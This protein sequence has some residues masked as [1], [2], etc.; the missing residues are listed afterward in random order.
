MSRAV[1]RARGAAPTWRCVG[2]GTVMP[3]VE[4]T[5]VRA[6]RCTSYPQLDGV[7]SVKLGAPDELR[8]GVALIRRGGRDAASDA[9]RKT[10][11][12][13][14]IAVD[15]LASVFASA[16]AP[17]RGFI[18]DWSAATPD[19]AAHYFVVRWACP[20]FLAAMAMA[21]MLA[22]RRVLDLGAGVGHLAGFLRAVAPPTELMIADGH[23]LH[24]LV[25]RT[26]FVPGVPA[27]CLDL[28]QPLPLPDAAFDAVVLSD[29]FHYV[30]RKDELLREVFRV[31]APEG[32]LVL[33]HV[34]D[35]RD[36]TG[37]RVPGAP[38]TPAACGSM[39]REA[40]LGRVRVRGIPEDALVDTL[41]DVGGGVG[42]RATHRL[43]EMPAGPYAMWGRRSHEAPAV[44]PRVPWERAL[45]A[46]ELIA[47]PIYAVRRSRG[48]WRLT[49]RWPSAETYEEFGRRPVLPDALNLTVRPP[50]ALVDDLVR[51]GVLIAS[52]G[53]RLAP[54][55]GLHAGPSPR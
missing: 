29:C 1:R 51:R 34:H 13:A 14:A 55:L 11:A 46:G 40:A 17:A 50:R 54:P 15:A 38:I 33:V 52:L 3:F 31:L 41:R 5:R 21:P 7:P 36:T 23:L 42:C 19:G 18:A 26:Y 6:C 16:P 8:E 20:S 47:N 28:D 25:A 53:G 37:E 24:L 48:G 30:D 22:G 43:D 39:I 27:I 44:P 32:D 49:L 35:A 45:P 12:A 9:V 2:C 4:G 10:A